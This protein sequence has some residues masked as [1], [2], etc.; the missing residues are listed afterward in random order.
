M[1]NN[2]T[3]RPHAKL[4]LRETFVD[5]DITD[6]YTFFVDTT[7]GAS[8]TGVLLHCNGAESMANLR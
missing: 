8:P 6:R 5:L 4:H 2:P 1:Q 3:T 7:A